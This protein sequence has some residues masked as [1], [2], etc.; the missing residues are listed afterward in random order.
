M[1]HDLQNDDEKDIKAIRAAIAAGVTHID[2][3]EVYADGYAEILISRAIQGYDR[4]KLFLTSK[5]QAAHLGYDD[6]IRSCE[7]S[8]ERLKT[9][10]LDL[11]LMHR[12]SATFPLKDSVRALNYLVSRGLVRNIG[13]SN[14]GKEHLAE[15][16]SY[17][18]NKIVCNQVHYNLTFREPEHK[19]LLQ[20]CQNNDI[21]L[22]AWRP[23]SKGRLIEGV[24][25]LIQSLCEK[26]A[27]TPAQIAINW[28]ISQP[29]VLTICKMG[30]E[31]HLLENLGAIGWAMDP[32]DIE[33]LR[34]EFP[35]QQSVS[36][37]I[38]LD[39]QGPAK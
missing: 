7:R 36:D 17:S 18:E 13:V 15:A 31:S 25:A 33:L 16:Q 8:L 2:T 24:P 37:V 23:L 3:A 35:D 12:Y 14:F 28:L 34:R 39:Q 5:V 21:F 6:I 4:S 11:Y 1:E 32:Y 19:G 29:N 22:V 9:S 27:K 10:Y 38:P 30:S 20:Y 26:Y